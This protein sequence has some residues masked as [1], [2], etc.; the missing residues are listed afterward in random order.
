MGL[1]RKIIFVTGNPH[2][3]IEA[4]GILSPLGIE[5]VQNNCGYPELQEDDLV[6]IARF[7]AQWAA[8][9]LNCEVMVDDSGI[10]I[11]ELSGF[12]GPYSAYVAKTLGNENILKIMEGVSN[13]SASLQCVI[14]YCRPG[15]EAVVFSGKVKGNIAKSIRG[16]LGFGYDPI[17]EVEGVTFGEMRDEEKNRISHRYRAL[18]KFAG[19]LKD[20]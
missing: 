8:N 11:E 1:W 16:K 17:F 12:P 19:W 3:V 20:G 14:G 7:G 2:K 10:F 6:A 13:R 5:I 15:E 4:T 9:K 18:V